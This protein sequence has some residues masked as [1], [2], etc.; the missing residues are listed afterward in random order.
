M[1]ITLKNTEGFN[2]NLAVKLRQQN[3]GE[4]RY[5]TTVVLTSDHEQLWDL[6]ELFKSASI[7]HH[8]CF[9]PGRI[10][11]PH[12]GA[13]YWHGSYMKQYSHL[14]K[15]DY[16]MFHARSDK[17]K[18]IEV[19]LVDGSLA[20]KAQ[21]TKYQQPEYKIDLTIELFPF[22]SY[23]HKGIAARLLSAV[24]LDCPLND[25]PE[26]GRQGNHIP[27]VS[28]ILRRTASDDEKYHYLQVAKQNTEYQMWMGK[29]VH[30]LLEATFKEGRRFLTREDY[31]TMLSASQLL[32]KDGIIVDKVCDVTEEKALPYYSNILN[33]LSK[34]VTEIDAIEER[35]D[36]NEDYTGTIDLVGLHNGKLSVIDYKTSGVMRERSELD[37]YFLQVAA[38]AHAWNANNDRK[39][40]RCVIAM[41]TK[42]EYR[43]FILEGEELDKYIER[44]MTKVEA[45]WDGDADYS[46]EK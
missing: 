4:P 30:K 17:N 5:Q 31:N 23:N 38:Y 44:W 45:Y 9:D 20:S 43:D 7:A 19:R 29:K 40:E 10:R 14:Y 22:N 2:R 34:N 8:G 32:M 15:G 3:G 21:I 13:D 42:N 28:H 1:N 12:V 35:F 11:V 24:L 41:A 36:F 46:G 27:P 16:L 18:E 37:N 6:D 25:E 33:G 39:I 26:V